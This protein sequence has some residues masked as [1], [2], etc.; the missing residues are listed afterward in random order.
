M[1]GEE[2]LK[3]MDLIDPELVAEAD[4]KQPKRKHRFLK[5]S[6]AVAAA[7]AIF[8]AVMMIGNADRGITLQV[9]QIERYYKTVPLGQSE[10]APVYPPEYLTEIERYNSMTLGNTVYRTRARTVSPDLLGESLGVCQLNSYDIYSDN[11]F[12]LEKPTYAISGI[13]P[14]EL[15]AVELGG[16]YCVFLKDTYSPPADFGTF[17]DSVSLR[18]HAQ[19][20]SFVHYS[21]QNE[22]NRQDSC[23]LSDDETLWQMLDKC[24][25]APYLEMERFYDSD[26][27]TVSFSVTSFARCVL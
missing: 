19:L 27:E 21:G 22:N 25:N 17:W 12:T 18:D 16:E 14:S 1:S 5:W 8:I 24:R 26:I 15:V 23:C 9:G 7:A 6:G 13:S 11:I 3:N 20:S 2:L 4:T 10:T